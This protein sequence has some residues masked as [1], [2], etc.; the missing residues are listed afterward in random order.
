MSRLSECPL[1]MNTKVHHYSLVCVC[2][3]IFAR[4]NNR[5][6]QHALWPCM[7]IRRVKK[8]ADFFCCIVSTSN[9]LNKLT[10]CN[11]L[12]LES[13]FNLS[14]IE[15]FHSVT[16]ICIVLWCCLARTLPLNTLGNHLPTNIMSGCGL[17]TIHC[18]H[19]ARKLLVFYIEKYR[20]SF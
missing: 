4:R 18:L 16:G 17:N 14:Q 15:E 8:T 2:N 3:V 9:L 11:I 1:K 6:N 20:V 7:L 13:H 19:A 10:V 12:P 5:P